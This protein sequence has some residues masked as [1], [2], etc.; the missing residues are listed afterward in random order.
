ME[1]ERCLILFWA[2]IINVDVRRLFAL[3]YFGLETG[4]DVDDV[5]IPFDVN[6]LRLFISFL[7]NFLF[8]SKI[9]LRAFLTSYLGGTY[10]SAFSSFFSTQ[11]CAHLSFFLRLLGVDICGFVN[12]GAL[13]VHVLY[14]H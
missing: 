1:L 12:V 8:A 14:V 3:V 13:R 11:Y 4:H 5:R 6:T 2:G 10:H 9:P 7:Y